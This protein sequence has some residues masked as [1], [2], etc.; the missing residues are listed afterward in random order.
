MAPS[1]LQDL[2]VYNS[3]ELCCFPG[4]TAPLQQLLQYRSLVTSTYFLHHTLGKKRL[5]AIH[6]LS[7]HRSEKCHQMWDRIQARAFHPQFKKYYFLFNLHT[8]KHAY[9]IP[10]QRSQRTTSGCSVNYQ[11]LTR[12]AVCQKRTNRQQNLWNSQSRAPVVFQDIQTDDSLTVDVAVIN[13]GTESNLQSQR[14][15][16]RESHSALPRDAAPWLRAAAVPGVLPA[17]QSFCGGSSSL[18]LC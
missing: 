12:V 4:S 14:K 16:Q 6:F 9:Y 2:W 11:L 18:L 5:T 15:R 8:I 3:R 10:W 7:C 13:S 1:S 17:L